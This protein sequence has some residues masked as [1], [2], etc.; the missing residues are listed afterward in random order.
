MSIPRKLYEDAFAHFDKDNTG[1]LDEKMF[2]TMLTSMGSNKLTDEQ[3]ERVVNRVNP[4]RDGQISVDAFIDWA[5]GPIAPKHSAP[6]TGVADNSIFMFQGSSTYLALAMKTDGKIFKKSE[7][8]QKTADFLCTN[9]GKGEIT[10]NDFANACFCIGMLHPDQVEWAP[11]TY[12]LS[13]RAFT[14]ADCTNIFTQLWAGFAHIGPS[15]PGDEQFI[16]VDVGTGE[17][18]YFWCSMSGGREC[19]KALQLD[20][21]MGQFIVAL[22]KACCHAKDGNMA[23]AKK[24]A[25]AAM[26]H[27]DRVWAS[28]RDLQGEPES[29]EQYLSMLRDACVMPPVVER[30]D[31]RVGDNDDLGGRKYS[32]LDIFFVCTE[33]VRKIQKEFGGEEPTS[34]FSLVMADFNQE[35]RKENQQNGLPHRRVDFA[36]LKQN[37]EMGCEA[38]AVEAAF[39]NAASEE[40]LRANPDF[41]RKTQDEQKKLKKGCFPPVPDGLKREDLRFAGNVAWGS[42]SA[43]GMGT[44]G[45]TRF[46]LSFSFK[47]NMEFAKEFVGGPHSAGAVV[48]ESRVNAKGKNEDWL[49]FPDPAAAHSEMKAVL[50]A[51]RDNTL[52]VLD[53]HQHTFMGYTLHR[54]TNK[55]KEARDFTKR[56]F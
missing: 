14:N 42:G 3:F 45:T 47:I 46:I 28:F 48:L 17:E 22:V 27:P 30:A 11:A 34:T 32:D 2:R 13:Q 39:K 6:A 40:Q 20:S 5:Q 21:Y 31:T 37:L 10:L 12:C 44:D 49:V 15:L 16:L 9:A 8:W 19:L 53:A 4:Q 36:V 24:A 41:E 23:E 43:Q 54:M 52:A 25:T 55:M 38:A 29:Y 51:Y 7:Y 1:Y 26:E 56:H 33:A 18:K 50:D 35:V